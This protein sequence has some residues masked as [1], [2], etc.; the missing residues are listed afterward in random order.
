[1]EALDLQLS[2]LL[3]VL[4]DFMVSSQLVKKLQTAQDAQRRTP[5]VVV[6][7]SRSNRIPIS[8]ACIPVNPFIPPECV[9]AVC[10]ALAK[11]FPSSKE[12]ILQRGRYCKESDPVSRHVFQFVLVPIPTAQCR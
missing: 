6:L 5:L 7:I 3:V 9:E 1:M 12:A 4:G 8:T 11:I 10:F 2:Q